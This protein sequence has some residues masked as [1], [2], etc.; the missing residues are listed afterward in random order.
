MAYQ[1][2]T[3]EF[4]NKRFKLELE[5]DQDAGP[6]WEEC[7]GHG[8]VSDWRRCYYGERPAKAPGERILHRDRNSYRTYD[9]AETM[10]IARRDGWGLGKEAEAALAQ[11]L[12]RAPTQGEIVA[13]SVRRDFEYLRA[14]CNDEW[15]YCGVIVTLLDDD[16]EE[17]EYSESL[18]RVE[19]NDD[20]Y[21]QEVARELAD[22]ICHRWNTEFAAAAEAD[23]PDLYQEQP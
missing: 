2:N 5:Y 21:V 6:P 1:V 18:W 3:F 14:W 13:E 22:E 11:T 9:V 20:A 16:G 8:I 17:T 4:Q 23:R 10:R 15:H 7:D 12:G 19:N